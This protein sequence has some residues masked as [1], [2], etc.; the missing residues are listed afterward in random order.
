MA[1]REGLEAVGKMFSAILR[2]SR[3]KQETYRGNMLLF[4]DGARGGRKRRGDLR[5]WLRWFLCSCC[6]RWWSPE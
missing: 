1:G 2:E 4:D 6:T 5:A 3:R